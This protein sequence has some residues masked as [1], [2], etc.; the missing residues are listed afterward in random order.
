[1][2]K[3]WSTVAQSW[4]TVTSASQVHAISCLSL[5]SSWDY[6]CPPSHQV[7]FF[8][9]L[10]ETRFRHVGQAGLELLTSRSTHLGLP[11]CWDYRDESPCPA[12]FRN[13]SMRVMGYADAAQELST[14]GS[15]PESSGR[16]AVA[17]QR[18]F[19]EG[20]HVFVSQTPA[21]PGLALQSATKSLPADQSKRSCSVPQ[22]GMSTVVP[23]QFTAA[24]ASWVQAI[25]LPQPPERILTLSPDL[26]AVAQSQLTATSTS[27]V[28]EI[29]LP[30]PPE[31]LGLQAWSPTVV[32][33]G[34]MQWCDLGSLQP[35][36]TRFKQ[37]SCLSL[38]KSHCCPGW[39]AVVRSELTVTSTSQVQAVSC[40][41]LPSSWDYVLSSWDYRRTPPHLANFCIFSRDGVSPCWPSYSRTPD[42]RQVLALSPRLEYSG[43]ISA[44]CNLYLPGS[45]HPPT[46]TSQVAETM[47]AHHDAWL[48]FVCFVEMGFYHVAQDGLELMSLSDQPASASQNAR[49]TDLSHCVQL[50][51]VIFCWSIFSSP[52]FSS[53]FMCILNDDGDDGD[54]DGDDNGDDGDGGDDNSDDGDDDGDD[55]GDDG[56]G[57]DNS[58]DGDDDGD[59]GDDN[60]DNGDD[61]G[62]DGDDN[63]DDGDDNGDDGSGGDDDG[64]DNGDG[65]NDDGDDDDD[66]D[67]DDG[68]GGDGGDDDGDDNGDGGDDDGDD[69]D[70]SGDDDGDNSDGGDDNSD[71]GDDDGDDDDG[72]DDNSDDGDD[73]GDDN[74][75]G[76]DDGDDDG[77]DNSDDGDDDGDNGDDG[78]DD[79]D[80][81]GDSDGDW[82]MTVM[83]VMMVTMMLHY[84]HPEGPPSGLAVVNSQNSR[85]AEEVLSSLSL[86][87]GSGGPRV[88]LGYC[89]VTQQGRASQEQFHPCSLPSLCPL[90]PCLFNLAFSA[91]PA[92]RTPRPAPP[93]ENLCAWGVGGGI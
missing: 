28:Q 13:S 85:L 44:H 17:V 66:D 2:I 20:G 36:P 34:G 56:D 81:D 54:D 83:V 61:D 84:P 35:P 11:K 86:E 93:E 3:G 69:G 41:S 53:T 12:C 72:G 4:L 91:P 47:G 78:D 88:G 5:Q 67:G 33:E 71:D 63:S 42:L 50:I 27:W 89:P 25:L 40:L 48:I 80:S 76:G 10:V 19:E 55:N 79:G 15:S 59:S 62:D 21:A 57:G 64:D 82:M 68:D 1:M 22:A 32:A 8:A 77:D 75:D 90:P 46:S 49:I 38:P 9:F 26:S 73:D 30:Q 29:P 16:M 51:L 58:D 60:S 70:D 23:S 14:P 45:S 74:G 87:G 7:N 65:G 52:I 31:E 43:T 37:F 92:P 24:S 39:N 18:A 6:R